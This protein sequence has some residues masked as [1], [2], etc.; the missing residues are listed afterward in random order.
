MG[1]LELYEAARKELADAIDKLAAADKEGD[2]LSAQLAAFEKAAKV[3]GADEKALR[4]ARIAM[5][6]K[7][8]AYN[9]KRS[10]AE[11]IH[12]AAIVKMDKAFKAYHSE[13]EGS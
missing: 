6:A 8:K 4:A 12:N 7:I 5:V 9:K 3:K 1:K 13:L 10:A 11:V 2:A